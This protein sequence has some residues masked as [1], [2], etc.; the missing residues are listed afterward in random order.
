MRVQS[1]AEAIQKDLK[2]SDQ[3][4]HVHFIMQTT[5][6]FRWSQQLFSLRHSHTPPYHPSEQTTLLYS[7]VG[8]LMIPTQRVSSYTDIGTHAGSCPWTACSSLYFAH[9]NQPL[10]VHPCIILMLVS[11]LPPSS[12]QKKHARSKL[13]KHRKEKADESLLT[14]PVYDNDEPTQH[15]KQRIDPNTE[16]SVYVGLFQLDM[17]GGS[18]QN[19]CRCPTLVLLVFLLVL[20]K[21]GEWSLTEIK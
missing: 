7:Q 6:S 3:K 21:E 13:G 5:F 14:C 9:K 16:E 15:K 1:Q 2:V 8:L 17:T 20:W 10:S 12:Q 19:V 11:L 4:L 18:L